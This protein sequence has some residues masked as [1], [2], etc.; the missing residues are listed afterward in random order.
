MSSQVLQLEMY[1][2]N[3]KNV[4]FKSRDRDYENSA[5][6]II[7]KPSMKNL[8]LRLFKPNKTS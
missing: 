5:L 2:G 4:L 1:F 8:V 6:T 3:L 7:N